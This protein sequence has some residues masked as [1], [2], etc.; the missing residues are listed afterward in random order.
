MT[1]ISR[2]I[3]PRRITFEFVIKNMRVSKKYSNNKTKTE[4][5]ERHLEIQ[6]YIPRRNAYIKI[7]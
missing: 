7:E 1:L 5:N 4:K 6:L 3:R 2:G